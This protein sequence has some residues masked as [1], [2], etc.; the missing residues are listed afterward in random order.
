MSHKT[1]PSMQDQAKR[2]QDLRLKLCGKMTLSMQSHRVVL[3]FNMVQAQ[4]LLRETIQMEFRNFRNDLDFLSA[5]IFRM[6][7]HLNK[8]KSKNRLYFKQYLPS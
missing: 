7:Q 3:R 8:S 6:L 2:G 5:T 4:V 1:Q